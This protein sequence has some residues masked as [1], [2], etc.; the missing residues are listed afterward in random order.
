MERIVVLVTSE[1][2][3]KIKRAAGMISLS[4]W[5]KSLCLYQASLCDPCEPNWKNGLQPRAMK[6]KK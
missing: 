2:K 4:S 5:V 6:A 3:A 1:E